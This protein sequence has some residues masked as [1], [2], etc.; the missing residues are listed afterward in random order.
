MNTIAVHLYHDSTISMNLDGEF[1]NIE[2]ERLYAK[3]HYDWRLEGDG[4]D[5]LLALIEHEQKTFDAAVVVGSYDKSAAELFQRLSIPSVGQVDH[6]LAHAA[7]AFFQSPYERSLVISYDGGGNDGTFRAFLA[8]RDRGICSIDTNCVLNLGIPY[9][10]L[11]YPIADIHK[12][13]DQR[14][15]SNAGKLMGLAAYGRVRPDWVE[16]LVAYY[17]DCSQGGEDPRYMYQWVVAHL[18]QLGSQIGLSLERDS[19]TG[20]DAFDFAMTGQHVFETLFLERVLPL[21]NHYRLP[22]CISGGCALNVIVNQ[23]LAE[24]VDLPIFIPPNPNDCGLALGALLSKAAPHHPVNV[25]YSGIGIVDRRDLSETVERYRAVEVRPAHVAQLLFA[26][27]VVAVMRGNAEHG[28]RALGNRSILCDPSV[29]GMK[30]RLNGRVK[31]REQF[32]PYAPV[33]Q[34]QDADLYFDNARND[35]SFMSFNPTVKSNW[36]TTFASAVHIDGTARVQTVTSDQ[37]PWLYE[38]LTEFRRL[39]GYGALL[40]TSF[41]SKGKPMVARISDALSIFFATDIDFLLIENWLFRKQH[42]HQPEA[43][44]I[45]RT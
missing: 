21:A 6:H 15:L 27:N 2:L 25:T 26:G 17:H 31:F 8:C 19:L 23:R 1:L 42:L 41:N 7:A 28:P 20:T 43:S 16:P 39:S 38:L 5:E 29:P 3:R 4:L 13:N 40:N 32:R 34:A 22:I 36:R 10:A 18:E 33:V 37:H 14:E 45:A 11:A 44:P 30:D 24:I 12:P 9:R 35:M